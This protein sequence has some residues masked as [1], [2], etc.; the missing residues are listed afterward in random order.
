MK[1]KCLPIALT[2][3]LLMSLLIPGLTSSAATPTTDPIRYFNFNPISY[4][5]SPGTDWC[6][7]GGNVGT[8]TSAGK[9]EL[10]P[11]GPAG[12]YY[13]PASEYGGAG[14]GRILNFIMSM[15][16][17]ISFKTA[18]ADWGSMIIF[19]S[20]AANPSWA[21]T[22]GMYLMVYPDKVLIYKVGDATPL[23]I[24]YKALSSNIE[25]NIRLSCIDNASGGTDVTVKITD[26]AGVLVKND[27]STTGYSLKADNI[28]GVSEAGY[29][30]L[31]GNSAVI[32][33]HTIAT[34][35]PEESEALSTYNFADLSASNWL[36]EATA[37]TVENGI[38]KITA[39]DNG[40]AAL[41]Y[42]GDGTT[43]KTDLQNVEYN[44][45][46]KMKYKAATTGADWGLLA[47][48][49]AK[50]PMTAAWDTVGQECYTLEMHKNS[51]L[52]VKTDATGVNTV[53]SPV[54]TNGDLT[55]NDT[56]FHDLKIRISRNIDQNLSNI[57]VSIDGTQIYSFSDASIQVP[58]GLFLYAQVSKLDTFEIM[59]KAEAVVIPSNS[60]S[61]TSSTNSTSGTNPDTGDNFYILI[62]LA[63]LVLV[64]ISFIVA[65]KAKLQN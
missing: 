24:L 2:I 43:A 49:A 42:I 12:V 26:N 64:S 28:A 46:I 22:K 35:L 18:A 37:S 62:V 7:I 11:T 33:K 41:R 5:T 44:F 39:G 51:S 32:D 4:G 45:R 19:R 1:K 47:S 17:Q 27:G 57:Y 21:I 10:V 56:E 20:E 48:F 34:G 16:Y 52:L 50:K 6:N 36:I 65:K 3:V 60:P 8:I 54:Q 14:A 61:P 59:T 9:L 29:L 63:T 23:D 30:T 58:G 31:F 55:I 15:K 40:L 53:F 25:Y 13:G 38:L